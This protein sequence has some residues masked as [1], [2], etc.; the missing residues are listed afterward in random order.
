LIKLVRF[1][2]RIETTFASCE[3][4]MR[5]VAT[6]GLANGRYTTSYQLDS[7]NSQRHRQPLYGFL[8]GEPRSH[9]RSFRIL[10][11]EQ[12]ARECIQFTGALSSA[13]HTFCVIASCFAT[14]YRSLRSSF[15]RSMWP[16]RARAYDLLA[17]E[18]AS[19][20]VSHPDERAWIRVSRLIVAR[21][22]FQMTGSWSLINNIF[23]ISR[24][25]NRLLYRSRW[26]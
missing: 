1:H 8:R 15:P 7:A 25:I 13:L 2:T 16:K 21:F 17:S 9:G 19:D 3:R 20:H 12:C 4:A 5:F 22:L 6:K 11:R 26:K 18:I 14:L 10:L 24:T 23:F